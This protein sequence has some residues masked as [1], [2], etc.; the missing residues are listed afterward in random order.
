MTGKWLSICLV[1]AVLLS[2][3]S[4][5][6]GVALA[7]DDSPSRDSACKGCHEDRYYLYDTGRWYCLCGKQRNCI[8]CHK[9]NDDTW[10][11][12]EAHDGLVVNPILESPDICQDCHPDDVQEYIDKFSAV[13]GI[14]PNAIPDPTPTPYIPVAL[15]SGKSPSTAVLEREARGWGWIAALGLLGAALAGV[16]VFGFRCWKADCLARR[17]AHVS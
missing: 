9:G 5:I 15:V 4:G 8:D 16:F 1:T 7:Q 3:F 2:V 11:V 12:D 17:S 14:D 13:A 6:D 10:I